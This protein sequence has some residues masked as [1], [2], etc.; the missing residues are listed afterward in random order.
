MS[1]LPLPRYCLLPPT[2]PMGS[3][4]VPFSGPNIIAGNTSNHVPS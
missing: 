1:I 2:L 4:F 3:I